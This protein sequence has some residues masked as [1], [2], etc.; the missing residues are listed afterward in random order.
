MAEEKNF[1]LKIIT[2]DRTFFE[3]QVSMVEFATTEG[4]MGVY[5]SHIP[6][7]AVLVPTVV[8]ITEEEGK[9]E[10]AVHSG[11]VEVLPERVTVLAEIAEW[12]EEIDTNRAEEA[13][14]RAERRLQ[15]KEE[16]LNVKRAELALRKA[17]VRLQIAKR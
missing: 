4:E 1:E 3:G 13:R 9:R 8:V 11:F 5:R 15:T 7:T 6:L 10:A 16:N 12:P 2:P 17:L 14:I